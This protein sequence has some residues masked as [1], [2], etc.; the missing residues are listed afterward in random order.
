MVEGFFARCGKDRPAGVA[1][2]RRQEGRGPR[3]ASLLSAVTAAGIYIPSL[4]AHP[5]LPPS[6]QR[7][8]GDSGCNLCVVEIAGASGM[9]TSC[10][11]AV[12]ADMNITTQSPTIDKLRKERIAKILGTH[13]HVCLTCPQR[14]GC[15]RTT[16]SFGNPV[17][18]RCCSIFSNCELRK[19]SDYI[20]IPATTPPYKSI[21]LPVIRT[22]R[23]T[24]AT[25]TCA[26]TAAA[27]WWPAT[28]CAASAASK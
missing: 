21:Q 26:S 15:S 5:D 11:V 6:C 20:G 4:C 24:T 25:T 8:A 3:G 14:E 9:R 16:C 17:E 13:P 7:G 28:R 23:S 27:A 18:T 12:E 10:S 1:H 22:S 19:V 2:H